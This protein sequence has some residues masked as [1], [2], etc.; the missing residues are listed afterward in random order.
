MSLI[1][2]KSVILYDHKELGKDEFNHPI[3]EEIPIVV[4]NVLIEPIIQSDVVN[5][6]DLSNTKLSYRLYIPKGDKNIWR[7]RKVSFFGKTFK[8]YGPVTEYIDE[9]VPL[10]WNKK[11]LVE[12]YGSD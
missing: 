7:D 12:V 4:N 8:T 6:V 10:D 1:K 2:G 3:Y 9:L 11:V 5:Q